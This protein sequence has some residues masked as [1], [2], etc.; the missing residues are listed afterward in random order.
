MSLSKLFERIIWHN[1]TT[2]AINE[3]NLNAMSKGIDDIDDRVIS[4]AGTIME[5]VPQIQSYLEQADNLVD[6]L[7][8]LTTNPPYIGANGNWYTWD[9]NTGAYVDSGIDASITVS[10]GTTTTLTPGSSA[11]VTNSGTNTDPVLNFGIPQ[12]ATGAAG[13]SPEV[14]VTTITG[15]H[16]VT[17]TDADHP[18]G[19]SFNVMDGAGDMS[20]SVYDPSSTVEN[21]GGIT[22]Y[23]SG[24]IPTITVDNT[25]TASSSGTRYQRF[26]VNGSYTTIDGT[27][28]MEISSTSSTTYTFTNA[29]ISSNSVIDVYTDT[30]GDNPSAVTVS[31]TTCTVTFS[32]AQTRTVRI[33]IR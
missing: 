21:A 29:D 4:L 23:V 9:T 3:T 26:G 31:G 7:E 30:W 1:N 16:T 24:Q 8:D 22:A 5:T 17:I 14:T 18:T 11:T 2:P 19:Q 6:T 25:G 15:G 10:V 32:A 13:V 27:K 12:G 33:Y 20:K 28:Y